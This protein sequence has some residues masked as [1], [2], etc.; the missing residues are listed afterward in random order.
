M[1]LTL[2][3]YWI[4]SVENGKRLRRESNGFAKTG[5]RRICKVGKC[6]GLQLGRSAEAR[7]SLVCIGPSTLEKPS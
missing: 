7:T 5:G 4:V 6:S 1:L 2:K 3:A